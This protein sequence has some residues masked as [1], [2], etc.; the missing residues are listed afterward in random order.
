MKNKQTLQQFRNRVLAQSLLKSGLFGLLIGCCAA[1]LMAFISWFV[2]FNGGLWLSIGILVSVTAGSGALLYFTKF[3][4][5]NS[6]LARRIDMLGLDE[7]IVTMMELENDDSYIAQLQ[8]EDAR[9]KLVTVSPKQLK[10]K[11]AKKNNASIVTA[12]IIAP[13]MMVICGLMAG[14][15]LSSGLDLINPSANERPEIEIEYVVEEGG[16]IDGEEFQIIYKGEDATPVMAIADDGWVFV[17]WDDGAFDP[18][19]HD[20]TLNESMMFVAIFE[21]MEEGSDDSSDSEGNGEGEGAGDMPGESNNKNN[22]NGEVKG[23]GENN[24]DGDGK[25]EDAS[26]KHSESNVVVNGGI[27]YGDVFDGYYESAMDSVANGDGAGSST[28][29]I[30][31]GYFEGLN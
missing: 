26:G 30:V 6:L 25:G 8:R 3:R 31:S 2:G 24:G 19:R 15:F 13:A 5:T 10:F 23:N 12:A 7:R 14:G 22:G 27:D 21:E 11:M 16:T 29:D 4:V 18:Y 1:F 9:K 28:G 17:G 20:K